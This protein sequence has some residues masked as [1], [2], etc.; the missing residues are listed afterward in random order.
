MPIDN[1]SIR[2]LVDRILA[3]FH[4][5]KIILFGSHARGDAGPDS[6]V[7]LLIVMPVSGSR[8]KAAVEIGVALEDVPVPTD[9]VVTTPDDYEW[10]KEVT[11]TIEYPAFHEGKVLYAAS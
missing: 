1:P 5:Q 2:D 4:P 9:I 3:R 7:D 8:R 10:R 6:D 11:G